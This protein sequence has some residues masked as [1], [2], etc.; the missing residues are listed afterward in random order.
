ME[1]FGLQVGTALPTSDFRLNT[2]RGLLSRPRRSR[3]TRASTRK[4]RAIR[5][6]ESLPYPPGS[7]VH[8]HLKR[9]LITVPLVEGSDKQR[10][11]TIPAD[12]PS[13][14]AIN[15]NSLAK[16][17]AKEQLLTDLQF[18]Q[19]GIAKQLRILTSYRIQGSPQRQTRKRR[20]RSGH[21]C[22]RNL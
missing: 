10:P 7:Y 6:L 2:A 19:I 4:M 17:H 22:L 13:V 15:V 20:R 8:A 16:A 21:L 11:R 18:Y 3:G 14:Y 12:T 5:V 1:N 9:T